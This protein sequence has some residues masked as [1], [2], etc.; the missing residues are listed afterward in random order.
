MNH[1]DELGMNWYSIN[2]VTRRRMVK[3]V[4]QESLFYLV[5]YK[6]DAL[7]LYVK[8]LSSL[9]KSDH[10]SMKTELGTSFFH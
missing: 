4:L 9:G 3:G 7:F 1:F 10:V 6:D 2:K 5:L 8:L